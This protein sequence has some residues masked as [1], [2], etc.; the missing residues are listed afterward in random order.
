MDLHE[1]FT[2]LS[3]CASETGFFFFARELDEA[4]A[5]SPHSS[6]MVYD[7]QDADEPFQ[8]Y[9]QDVGW[10]AIAMATVKPAGSSRLVVAIGPN[11]DFWEVNPETLEEKVG[12]IAGF[13]GNLRALRAIEDEIYACGM[14]RVVLK[15]Q[16]AGSWQ[17][18]APPRQNDDP[19]VTGFENIAG[20]DQGEM[21]AVGWGGEIWWRDRGKWRRVDS[22]TSINL[23]ALCCAGDGNVYVVGQSGTMLRGRRDAWTLLETGRQE[24]LMDVAWFG[25]RT[26]VTTDFRILKL[27]GDRLVNETEFADRA[28]LPVTCLSLLPASDGLVS[29]G[30]KDVFT[31]QA[32]P[33]ARLV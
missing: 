4:A 7:D 24:N 2:I 29:L 33:W 31:R 22:P 10:P 21:Y 11:G 1:G 26:H 3:G 32:G 13:K 20:F 23:R 8:K 30:Q 16:R 18:L 12:V 15:R 14:G 6:F 25:G 27:H 9:A 5:E 19:D 28:D 17:S